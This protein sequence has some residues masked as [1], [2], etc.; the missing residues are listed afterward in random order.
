MPAHVLVVGPGAEFPGI[1]RKI[2]G[3]DTRTSVICRN[4][5][6]KLIQEPDRQTRIVAL[7]ADATAQTWVQWAR[8]IHDTDPVTA[9]GAFGEQDQDRATDIA[10]ALGLPTHH[11]DTVAAIHNKALMRARLK[12]AGIDDTPAAV[13]SDHEE[14]RRFAEQHG[15]PLIAKPVQGTASSFVARIESDSELAAGF[16]YAGTASDRS[17]GTVLLEKFM[18]GPQVSVEAL[19]ENGEHLVVGVTAK[20]SDPEHLIEVGHACPAD[21]DMAMHDEIVAYVTDVLNALGVQFGATHTELVLTAEGPRII[22]SHLRLGG[23]RIADLVRE[24]L[25]VDLVDC[26]A[27]QT[28]GVAVLEDVAKSLATGPL[29]G[30]AIWFVAPDL[31]G[32]LHAIEGVATATGMAG[33]TEVETLIMPGDV[34]RPLRSSFDR[35]ASVR[36]QAGTSAEAVRLARVAAESID[37]LVR[38]DQSGALTL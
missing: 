38:S 25:G 32:T 24:A 36:A 20:F 21:L 29:C 16:N 6:V 28:L 17:S 26:V 5:R 14:A 34:T 33:V 30:S 37:F 2:G 19:S 13:V 10:L 9:V 23:D 11:P 12:D 27:K 8:S 1:I 31:R 22:E 15:Y 35:G 3:P 7:P 18:T 4:S